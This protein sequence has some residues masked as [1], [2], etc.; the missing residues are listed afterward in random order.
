M[1]ML[2]FLLIFLIISCHNQKCRIVVTATEESNA[3]A[4]QTTTETRVSTDNLHVDSIEDSMFDPLSADPSCGENERECYSPPESTIELETRTKIDGSCFHGGDDYDEDE[5]KKSPK[6][7]SA[8]E[9]VIVDKHWGSDP[10]ILKMRDQLRAQSQDPLS[11]SRPPIFLMPGLAS[12]R[13]VAWKVKKCSGAF[14]SDIK[15]QDN[16]WLNINLVIQM[17]TVNVDCMKDCLKLG[18]NQSDNDDWETGCKLRPDEGLD[19]IASLAP[20][21]IGSS[22]L[23]GG[24]NTV[25]AWLIQWL[26]DNLG[27]DVTNI[28]GLPYDWRLSPDKMEDRDGFLSMTRRRIEAAVASNGQPG[29]MVAHSMGNVVFRYFMDWLRV[30]MREESYTEYVRRSRRRAKN[31]KKMS[32]QKA[33]ASATK[34]PPPQQQQPR[35]RMPPQAA[36][37]KTTTNSGDDSWASNYLP[38]WMT[39]AVSSGFDGLFEYIHPQ[40]ENEGDT[41]NVDADGI[42]H[43]QLWQLAVDEGDTKWLEWLE[44]HIWS[45]V[46]LSAPMLGATN[47]MRAVISGE[48][49][50]LPMSDE[51]A[52]DMEVSKCICYQSHPIDAEN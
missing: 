11:D 1:S 45:Y 21:G 30:Q 27:Y 19:A 34:Q 28:I 38:G 42:N 4:E 46:G 23:V 7:C 9:E 31:L 3:D 35:Q 16:V 39:S 40:P 25:Y 13:L 18:L 49:M 29:I 51:I 10:K 32:E 8:G 52:R 26:A 50:G 33:A 41:T 44:A 36:E 48:N 14:A 37:G 47:P 2:H 20:G 43:A 5:D 22:L 12:T 24:T 6:E 15:V 17:G